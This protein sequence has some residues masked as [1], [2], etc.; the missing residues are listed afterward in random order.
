MSILCIY[1]R[2]SNYGREK[3]KVVMLRRS[4][5]SF[6]LLMFIAVREFFFVC[7]FLSFFHRVGS[8]S[9]CMHN[10]TTYLSNAFAPRNLVKTVVS[11]L[12]TKKK[13]FVKNILRVSIFWQ[14]DPQ[15][16]VA[17]F[18]GAIW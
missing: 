9:I 14:D 6:K 16:P 17:Q 7:L 1:L 10:F 3:G 2:C 18:L 8:N 4:S 12:A 11:F 13:H 5:I 15:T